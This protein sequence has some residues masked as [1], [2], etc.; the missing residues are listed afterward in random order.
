MLKSGRTGDGMDDFK[1]LEKFSKSSDLPISVFEGRNLVF[2]G[3]KD[4]QDYGMPMFLL[5]CLPHDLPDIWVGRTPENLFF[6]G[7]LFGRCE[8]LLMIGP[9]SANECSVLQCERTFGR[10]GGRLREAG[11]LQKVINGFAPCDVSHLRNCLKLLNY[12]LNGTEDAE[13]S[14]IDF[15]WKDLFFDAEEYLIEMPPETEDDA[16]ELMMAFIRNGKVK[17]LEVFLNEKLFRMGSSTDK[18]SR[19]INE[20]RNY[21]IGANTLISRMAIQE[22]VD[23]RMAKTLS[24]YYL[25]LLMRTEN[26]KDLDEIFYKLA[27]DYTKRIESTKN[28]VSYETKTLWTMRTLRLRKM[29]SDAAALRR[30]SFASGTLCFFLQNNIYKT[31][32]KKLTYDKKY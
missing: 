11:A 27:V 25:D 3:H 19:N 21:I 18:I 12:V 5:E 23:A 30:E 14:G 2:K 6:G 13:V 16:E 10:L 7:L 32:P 20:R 17:E 22:G 15:K 4:K 31:K 28:F 1:F 29:A 8:R 26:L 9:V 24:G